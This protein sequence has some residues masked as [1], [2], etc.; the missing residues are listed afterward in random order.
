MGLACG[1]NISGIISEPCWDFLQLYQKTFRNKREHASNL[2]DLSRG[3]VL[4]DC[5]AM[6]RQAV[7]LILRSH[8]SAHIKWNTF[9]ACM[10]K[11]SASQLNDISD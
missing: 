8:K 7:H 3:H 5:R 10:C 11:I 4:V 1:C 9:H 6:Y 2:Q